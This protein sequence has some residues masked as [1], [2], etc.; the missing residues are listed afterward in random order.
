MK[1]RKTARGD[2]YAVLPAHDFGTMW[3]QGRVPNRCS[4]RIVPLGSAA[5]EKPILTDTE[6]CHL[7]TSWRKA[8]RFGKTLELTRPSQPAEAHG[9]G[10]REGAWVYSFADPNMAY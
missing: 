4:N 6:R 5:W 1:R 7:V 2:S 10:E 9:L 8:D 3:A